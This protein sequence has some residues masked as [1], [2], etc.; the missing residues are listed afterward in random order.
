MSHE[1]CQNCKFYN[2]NLPEADR[3][4]CARYPPAVFPTGPGKATSFWPVVREDQSCGEWK[5]RLY[6]AKDLPPAAMRQ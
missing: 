3:G 2:H 6:L 4:S 1:T 5:Q